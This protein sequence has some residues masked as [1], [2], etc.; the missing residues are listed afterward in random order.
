MYCL[1]EIVASSFLVND[2]LVYSSCGE[3][4]GACGLYTGESFVVSEVEV[5]LHSVDCDITL[6]V[7]VGIECSGV[8]IDVRVKLLD[9]DVVTPCLQQFSYRGRDDSF[10]ER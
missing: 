7:F 4:V 2:S 10:A 5:C 3:R 6:S 1:A 8:D 9:G